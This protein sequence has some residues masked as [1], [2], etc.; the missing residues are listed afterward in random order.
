MRVAIVA[1]A[2]CLLALGCGSAEPDPHTSS[3]PWRLERI[4]R[5]GRALT[6]RYQHGACDRFDRTR[7]VERERAVTVGVLLRNEHPDRP[8]ILLLAVGRATVRL[9]APLGARR[10]LHEPVATARP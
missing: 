4:S 1:S 2:A 6:V 8:C 7:V 10:L 9:N 5:D 3:A